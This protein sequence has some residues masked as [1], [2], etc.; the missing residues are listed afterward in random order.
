MSTEPE[1][2]NALN[3]E[4]ELHKTKNRI[5]AVDISRML[6]ALSVMYYHIFL[7]QGGGVTGEGALAFFTTVMGHPSTIFFVFA[8]YFAC[9]NITWKKALDNAW[10]CIAPFVLWNLV[11]IGVQSWI[12]PELLEGRSL[13]DM[14][15][16]G[17]VGVG[18]RLFGYGPSDPVNTSLW[19]MR[20]LAVLFLLSPLLY[21]CAKVIFPILFIFAVFHETARLFMHSSLQV[22]SPYSVIFFTFGCYLRTFSKEGQKAVLSFH[23]PQWLLAYA[24]VGVVSAAD[25]L[26]HFTPLHTLWRVWIFM[27]SLLALVMMYWVARYLEVKVAWVTP[28]A[29]KF[30]PVTFLTFAGH[31][32]L[33]WMVERY[34]GWWFYSSLAYLLPIAVFAFM[35]GLFFGL[36]RWCPPL[37]HLVAHYKIRPDDKLG[38]AP[39]KHPSAG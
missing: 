20:D 26:F 22:A 36:K 23:S 19:F 25:I 17:Q 1:I 15:G 8:G 6:A 24:V 2:V 39:A 37:L 3:A 12:H 16:F 29:L 11:S 27:P 34:C 18:H 32:P 7:A 9:R 14:F 10:W 31:R 33:F 38:K 35:S 13:L 30:A 4:Q 5:V 21:K 28:L